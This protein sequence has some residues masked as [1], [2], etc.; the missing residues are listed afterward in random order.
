MIIVLP[1]ILIFI[2]FGLG[3]AFGGGQQP[4]TAN[5]IN[6]I[7]AVG[8]VIS[9]VV[10]VGTLW[11]LICFRNDWRIPKLDESRLDLISK[12]KRWNRFF[13]LHV[14][15][16]EKIDQNTILAK[17]KKQEILNEI[18]TEKRYWDELEASFDTHVY[19]EPKFEIMSSEFEELLTIRQ[20]IISEIE[21]IDFLNFGKMGIRELMAIEKFVFLLNARK[22]DKVDK[23]IIKMISSI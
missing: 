8:T 14:H 13:K 10:G 7:I 5:S 20:K 19:Y 16:I 9:S 21:N 23:L 22:L 6:A 18:T 12:A 4:D 11:L 3:V 1:F 2:V 17:E 15:K